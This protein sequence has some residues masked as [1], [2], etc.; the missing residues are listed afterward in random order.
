MF[1]AAAASVVFAASVDGHVDHQKGC[2]SR[3]FNP[4]WNGQ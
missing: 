3:I 2:D 4:T 1:S